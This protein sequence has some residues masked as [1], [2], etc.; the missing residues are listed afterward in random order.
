M[1]KR[2]CSYLK[3]AKEVSITF[4][5]LYNVFYTKLFKVESGFIFFGIG[6]FVS[7]I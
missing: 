4:K 2:I 6:D 1:Y 5:T 7:E 3:T